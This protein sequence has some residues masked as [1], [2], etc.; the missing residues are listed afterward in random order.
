MQV[1]TTRFGEVEIEESKI[2]TFEDGIPGFLEERQFV[3]MPYGED[4]P[5]SFL[6]SATEDYLAFLMTD[7]FL[8]F[9]D[10]EFYL[11]EENMK[12]LEVESNEDIAIF[13]MITVPVD[14]VKAM[15][16]NLVAPVV[17]NI[18]TRKAK[19]IV[20]EK[21]KYTTKHPVFSDTASE[22]GGE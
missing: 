3:I 8:F 21:T 1:K 2:I 14:N 13:S 6:Q 15:T 9:Q 11:D 19:Q 10:Y 20:L 12:A 16:A 18:K 17:I 5:F 22:K 4:S 7:P